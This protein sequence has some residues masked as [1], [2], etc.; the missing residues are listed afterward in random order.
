MGDITGWIERG[1]DAWAS[2]IFM[3]LPSLP[4]SP[5]LHQTIEVGTSPTFLIG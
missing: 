4:V 1:A 5:P 3:L 2:S